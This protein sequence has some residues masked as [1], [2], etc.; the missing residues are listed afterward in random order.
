[1]KYEF[2][3]ILV[4]EVEDDGGSIR[5]L[6]D[7]EKSK[8]QSAIAANLDYVSSDMDFLYDCVQERLPG[9]LSLTSLRIKEPSNAQQVQ[10]DT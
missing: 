4:V 1:M 9:D 2:P 7:E 5:I 3:L 10:K 8:L 6:S